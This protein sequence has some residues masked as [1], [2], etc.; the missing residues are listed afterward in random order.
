MRIGSPWGRSKKMVEIRDGQVVKVAGRDNGVC[1]DKTGSEGL[2]DTRDEHMD[3]GAK[4]EKQTKGG[5][6]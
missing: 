2:A 3:E 1:G 4:D 6:K 5:K